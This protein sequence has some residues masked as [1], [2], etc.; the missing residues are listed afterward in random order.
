MSDPWSRPVVIPPRADLGLWSVSGYLIAS[1][2]LA[3]WREQGI[4]SHLIAREWLWGEIPA[5]PIGD[6]TGTV[7]LGVIRVLEA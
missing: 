1:E 3:R 5:V 6:A 2:P 7:W 4:S